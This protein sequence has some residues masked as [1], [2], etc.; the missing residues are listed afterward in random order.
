MQVS[1]CIV[2]FTFGGLVVSPFS[3]FLLFIFLIGGGLLFHLGDRSHQSRQKKT[4]VTESVSSEAERSIIF[5]APTSQNVD[6][7]DCYKDQFEHLSEKYQIDLNRDQI[8]TLVLNADECLL[9]DDSELGLTPLVSL[10]NGKHF[11]WQTSTIIDFKGSSSD[12]RT[13]NLSYRTA[14]G[15]EIS[16]P[17][18]IPYLMFGDEREQFRLV[19]LTGLVSTPR[20][21]FYNWQNAFYQ[22]SGEKSFYFESVEDSSWRLRGNYRSSMFCDGSLFHEQDDKVYVLTKEFGGIS[23]GMWHKKGRTIVFDDF[24]ESSRFEQLFPLVEACQHNTVSSVL[25]LAR[26]NEYRTTFT[27]VT[28]NIKAFTYGKTYNSGQRV[29]I[30]GEI[31]FVLEAN[32]YV[33]QYYLLDSRGDVYSATPKG[34]KGFELSYFSNEQNYVKYALARIQFLNGAR[35]EQTAVAKEFTDDARQRLQIAE[36]KANAVGAGFDEWYKPLVSIASHAA[37]DAMLNSNLS[38]ALGIKTKGSGI[39]GAITAADATIRTRIISATIFSLVQGVSISSY[40]AAAQFETK[41][42]EEHFRSSATTFGQVSSANGLRTVGAILPGNTATLA[43]SF[44][45]GMA[46]QFRRITTNKELGYESKNQVLNILS[47]GATS[48]AQVVALNK[49][50]GAGR[51]KAIGGAGV[52]LGEIIAGRGY[53]GVVA[54]TLVEIGTNLA[55]GHPVIR[56]FANT[57]AS[58][59]SAL[60]QLSDAYYSAKRSGKQLDLA[61]G[62]ANEQKHKLNALSFLFE[63]DENF[64]KKIDH[65]TLHMTVATFLDPYREF[66]QHYQGLYK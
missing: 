39:Q 32:T 62:Y 17:D 38:K 15:T 2:L 37:S 22:P 64:I 21:S 56:P 23:T 18:T 49:G 3:K 28:D 58:Q 43:F 8:F 61:T 19:P 34:R 44:A 13:A 48:L 54:G 24:V 47:G 6:S 51:I 12:V 40:V 5:F 27:P 4:K 53:P 29:R 52:L 30:N 57:L 50:M 59:V 46:F 9:A 63:Q 45:S 41:S 20:G 36:V 14:P 35:I 33:K 16:S 65:Q 7:I 1:V 25:D 55:V 26:N 66:R 31:Y 10:K 60:M 11:V 42:A